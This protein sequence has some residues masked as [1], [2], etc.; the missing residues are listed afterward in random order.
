MTEAISPLRRSKQVSELMTDLLACELPREFRNLLMGKRKDGSAKKG[1]PKK[2]TL[3]T[4]TD[5]ATFGSALAASIVCR[6]LAGD[7]LAARMILYFTEGT[8][9]K[10][11]AP[12]IQPPGDGDVINRLMKIFSNVP[13]PKPE[14][15]P[16]PVEIANG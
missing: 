15:T 6:A 8:P 10:M 16:A 2:G 11:V 12:Y 13:E 14:E 5:G 4:L 9:T 3:P 7:M 1:R